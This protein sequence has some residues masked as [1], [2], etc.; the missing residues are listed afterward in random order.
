MSGMTSS[1]AGKPRMNASRITPS[2]PNT[3]AAG[4]KNAVMCDRIAVFPICTLASSQMSTPAGAATAAAL[5]RTN[6]VRS[7]TL[8]TITRPICGMR[9]GGSSSANDTAS[10]RKTVAE[11]MRDT[12]SVKPT[13][14]AMTPVSSSAPP[15]ALPAKNTEH[16]KISSG[17][18]PLHGAKLLVRMAIS[19]SRGESMMRQPVTPQALHPKPMHMVRLC[20]PLAL[21]HWKAWSS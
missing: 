9:Y 7:R 13:L 15:A 20:L 11:R 19:R 5:A 8:R 17:N 1:F 14:A 16:R 3:R 18:R 10:P 2:I 4:S 6:S 12:S 21:A